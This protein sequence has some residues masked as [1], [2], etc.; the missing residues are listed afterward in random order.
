MREK[1]LGAVLCSRG[2]LPP[3][4]NKTDAQH[5]IY[6][7]G[8]CLRK[9]KPI[10]LFES[11][12]MAGRREDPRDDSCNGETYPHSPDVSQYYHHPEEEQV[13]GQ[14][15]SR[16]ST[17]D[18]PVVVLTIHTTRLKA[19]PTSQYLEYAPWNAPPSHPGFQDPHYTVPSAPGNGAWR[20]NFPPVPA[21]ASLLLIATPSSLTPIFILRALRP[22]IH[23]REQEPQV[24]L[25]HIAGITGTPQV[26]H[27]F[28]PRR[29]RP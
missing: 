20:Q 24:E 4:K 6:C 19:P 27:G 1:L 10:L 13:Q 9:S 3:R 29:S 12:P 7:S 21:M 15:Q 8:I 14:S 28:T 16:V 11:Y 2:S 17:Q 26:R 22:K 5:T 18:F 25:F 23:I